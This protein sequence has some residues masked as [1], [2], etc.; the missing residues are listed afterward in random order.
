EPGGGDVTAGVTAGVTPHVLHM[1]ATPI[2]RTLALA[3]YGDL[4]TTMLREL[5]QG[6]QPID[7]R[8]VSG[9][10]ERARAYDELREQL[11]AG[12]QAYV[13]CPQIEQ[14][15]DA[16]QD[17]AREPVGAGS[18]RRPGGAND[19]RA[20]TAELERLRKGELAEHRL[21]LLHGAMKPR[22]EAH[23]SAQGAAGGAHG[24]GA[25]R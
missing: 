3:N 11:H 19:V 17:T 22:E 13:V 23:A 25:P 18:P 9:E 10:G 7:T 16:G 12:R 15:E 5:P 20:A 24:R 2:P 6:R 14:A 8:I 21:V 4:D 1:T